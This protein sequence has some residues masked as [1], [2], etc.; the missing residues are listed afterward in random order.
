MQP[1]DANLPGSQQ[2]S[3]HSDS[4][5]LKLNYFNNLADKGENPICILPTRKMVNFFNKAILENRS[6]DTIVHLVAIDEIYCKVNIWQCIWCFDS[7]I[8]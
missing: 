6:K 7:M 8:F 5:K 3:C 4:S 1:E 2:F